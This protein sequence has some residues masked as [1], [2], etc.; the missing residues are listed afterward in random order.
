MFLHDAEPTLATDGAHPLSNEQFFARLGQRV[1]H[2]LST[3]TASGALYQVDMRLRP[4]GNSGLLVTSCDAFERYQAESAT[5]W[6]QQAL[7]R[8]RPVA[9]SAA[10]AARF[11]AVRREVLCRPRERAAL[12]REVC[13]MRA[14][15]RAHLAAEASAQN[16]GLFDLKQDAGGIVDIEFMVQFT[17]WPSLSITR[18]S[19]AGPTTSASRT[20]S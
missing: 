7:V 13:A 12:A 11:A 9:G 5:V 16:Q 18:N 20:P 15:M 8:A 3:R 19:P 6:E 4:L 1:I 2:M 17:V 10:L 14:K